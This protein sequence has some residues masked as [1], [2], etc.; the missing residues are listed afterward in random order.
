[1]S[2]E[3]MTEKGKVIFSKECKR[4]LDL[5][6]EIGTNGDKKH[7]KREAKALLKHKYYWLHKEED[8]LFNGMKAV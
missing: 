5:C 2:V 3:A 1:M 6:H 4:L 8:T 7:E